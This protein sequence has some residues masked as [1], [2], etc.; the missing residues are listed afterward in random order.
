LMYLDFKYNEESS[1]KLPN[2]E[3]KELPPTTEY[4]DDTNFGELHYVFNT[5]EYT[6]NHRFQKL[7]EILNEKNL[8]E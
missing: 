2:I 3:Y 1:T 4:M 5:E 8:V 6:N 7:E